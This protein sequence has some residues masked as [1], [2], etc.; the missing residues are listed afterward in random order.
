MK[1]PILNQ[2]RCARDNVQ[3]RIPLD[4]PESMPRLLKGPPSLGRAWCGCLRVE[5]SIL[6]Q[7]NQIL[8]KLLGLGRELPD[9][10]RIRSAC[11]MRDDPASWETQ[12]D[13]HQACPGE[14]VTNRPSG[15]RKHLSN[16][17]CKASKRVLCQPVTDWQKPTIR[18]TVY[19]LLGKLRCWNLKLGMNKGLDFRLIDR[20]FYWKIHEFTKLIKYEFLKKMIKHVFINTLYLLY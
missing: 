9:S 6:Q 15:R 2:H 10:S 7:C 17:F 11:L 1:R 19:F 8:D 4:N 13:V 16:R 18:V 20:G 12:E 5:Y 3:F 14:R